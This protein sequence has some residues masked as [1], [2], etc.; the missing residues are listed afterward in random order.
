VTALSLSSLVSSHRSDREA[1]KSSVSQRVAGYFLSVIH[2]YYERDDEI[3][4]I[5]RYDTPEQLPN[6]TP[7]PIAG[8]LRSQDRTQQS[9]QN[10]SPDKRCLRQ[11][12]VEKAAADVYR[13]RI[14]DE[15]PEGF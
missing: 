4:P 6:D 7:K 1:A 5:A 9:A 11:C 10:G 8:G 3:L 12:R 15:F 14:A 13:V 2:E